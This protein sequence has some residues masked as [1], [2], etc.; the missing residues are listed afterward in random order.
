MITQIIT[1]LMFIIIGISNLLNLGVLPKKQMKI[2]KE[3]LDEEQMKK[4]RRSLSIPF[5]LLGIL[6]IIM[7]I[8]ESLS[9][10][11]PILYIGIYVILAILFIIMLIKINIKYTGYI[12]I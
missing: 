2:L 3:I 9:I 10:L 8:I 5:F 4:Y 12:R 7:G 6:C 11:N 1:G